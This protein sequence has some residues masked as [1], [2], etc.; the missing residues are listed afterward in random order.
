[1]IPEQSTETGTR[2]PAPNNVPRSLSSGTHSPARRLRHCV[3]NRSEMW[4][5]RGAPTVWMEYVP[6]GIE[7]LDG[8]QKLT[9][10][11]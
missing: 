6:V 1:M 9:D 10:V 3:T 4:P 8:F 2:N 7:S 5:A 11:P